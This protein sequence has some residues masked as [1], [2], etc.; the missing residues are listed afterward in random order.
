MPVLIGQIEALPSDSLKI[1][2]D[3]A[4]PRDCVKQLDALK[5]MFSNLR[6]LCTLKTKDWWR[7]SI[8]ACAPRMNSIPESGSSRPVAGSG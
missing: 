3:N 8:K 7:R 5:S 1:L 2:A 4:S 6:L